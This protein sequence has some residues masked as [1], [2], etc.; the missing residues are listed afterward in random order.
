MRVVL[1]LKIVVYRLILQRKI[2]LPEGEA[3]AGQGEAERNYKHGGNDAGYSAPPLK[4]EVR[5]AYRGEDAGEYEEGGRRADGGDGDEG[6]NEG[7]DDAADGVERVQAADGLAG[8]VKIVH[9][10]LRQRRRDRAE[11]D[12]RK[13]KYHKAGRER[14]PHEEVLRDECSQQNG[15]PGDEPAP[16]KRDERDPYRGDDDAA[17][18]PVGRLAFVRHAAAPDVADGHGYHYDADYH[19]PHDL[20]RAEIRRHEAACAQLDRHNGHSGEKFRQIEE[21]L[22]ADEFVFH[23]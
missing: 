22:A 6:R 9:R 14:R 19:R 11:Q 5:D 16:G 21:P 17:V 13:G 18:K 3:V 4:D 7:A 1:D 2:V 12:A 20:R 15:D 8:I 10:E 23:V